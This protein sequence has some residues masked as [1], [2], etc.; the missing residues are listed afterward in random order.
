M[1]RQASLAL[2]TRDGPHTALG[3]MPR[4]PSRSPVD[5][6]VITS[7]QS[8]MRTDSAC[9]CCQNRPR[10]GASAAP[11]CGI[12][13]L[14]LFDP[15][16]PGKGARHAF[17]GVLRLNRSA[18]LV[19]TALVA[20]GCRRSAWPASKARWRPTAQGPANPFAMRSPVHLDSPH[21]NTTPGIRGQTFPLGRWFLE[22]YFWLSD[23]LRGTRRDPAI[24]GHLHLRQQTPARSIEAGSIRSECRLPISSAR[25]STSTPTNLTPT[26]FVRPRY[27]RL[28]PPCFRSAQPDPVGCRGARRSIILG[29]GG[30]SLAWR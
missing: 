7:H 3:D 22:L 11:L 16:P 27:F 10:S 17:Q 5:S 20:R 18:F 21:V 15:S 12:A 19:V 2:P 4:F 23:R 1:D 14:A 6:L 24:Q 13:R 25:P 28:E 8:D 9:H 26:V 30:E 29:R